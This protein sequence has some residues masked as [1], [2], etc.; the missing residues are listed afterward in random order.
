MQATEVFEGKLTTRSRM[1]KFGALLT[2]PGILWLLIFLLLPT[3]FLMVLAFA[4]RGSYGSINW[5][6]SFANLT[7]LFGFSSF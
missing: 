3:I 4:E 6:F 1:R 5:N 2:G 7:R